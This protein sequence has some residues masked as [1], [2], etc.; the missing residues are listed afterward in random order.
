MS[1]HLPFEDR[2]FGL[3]Y[4]GSLF[5]HIDDLAE[6][7]LAELHRVLRPGGRLYFSIHD[8]HSVR[9]LEGEGD[10]AAYAGYYERTRARRTGIGGW[11]D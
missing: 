3:V 4:C 6:A 7:W 2:S 5:T 10:P 9:I 1:P 11:P 8:Q